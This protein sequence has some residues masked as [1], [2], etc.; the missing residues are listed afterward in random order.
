LL[1]VGIERGEA[2]RF[3][4]KQMKEESAR[5]EAMEEEAVTG[6]DSIDAQE[7]ELLDER[8]ELEDDIYNLRHGL[9]IA[10]QEIATWHIEMD[11]LTRRVCEVEHNQMLLSKD[12]DLLT[13]IEEQIGP[14]ESILAD[15]EMQSDMEDAKL[16]AREIADERME[17]LV[18][19][20]RQCMEVLALA[21][22][23]ARELGLREEESLKQ[24]LCMLR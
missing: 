17:P 7:L 16:L 4:E 18:L 24:Q 14:I 6:E 2:L 10:D 11:E 22:D 9:V 15:R 19:E 23:R 3:E 13:E 1:D 21:E 12:A 5:L 8:N 20:Y